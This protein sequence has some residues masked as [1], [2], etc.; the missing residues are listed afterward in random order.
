MS[1]G[2]RDHL[3][4]LSGPSQKMFV[5]PFLCPASALLLRFPRDSIMYLTARSLSEA[6]S[7]L[8]KYRR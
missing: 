1:D 7:L 2:V 8:G 4:L 3:K 5:D 6:S